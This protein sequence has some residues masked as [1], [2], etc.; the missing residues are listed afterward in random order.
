MLR[1][2]KSSLKNGMRV[3]TESHALSR[4]VS[5]GI[6]VLT[7]TRDELK[8]QEGISHLLEHLVFK[9]TKTRNAY[10]IA[11]SLESLGGELNA[12]TTKEYTVYH[13][14]VL[15]EHWEKGLEVL[16]DL[17]SNMKFSRSDFLLEKGVILQEIAMGDDNLEEMVF[18]ELYELVYEKHPLSQPI[19]GTLK[20][21]N[22]MSQKQV[23]DYYKKTY[24]ANN[25][26]VSAAGNVDHTEFLAA[27]ET[28]LGK[29]KK[30][31]INDQRTR[32]RFKVARKLIDRESE[33][34]H[35]LLAFN[36]QL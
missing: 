15:K 12:Y 7:G 1:F 25:M 36:A 2:Q 16:S 31:R 5:I 17:V 29:K 19:L 24:S 9:G 32:P 28:Y 20:S 6:W 26:I 22:G 14:L 34:A 3:V 8:G 30:T 10:Q 13:C 18:D 21:V 4:V 23:L 27:V 35:L 33:Q 11:K